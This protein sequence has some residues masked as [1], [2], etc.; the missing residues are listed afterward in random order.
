MLKGLHSPGGAA[1]TDSLVMLP[2]P[3]TIRCIPARHNLT[4]LQK[5]V[6]QRHF[7][8][9]EARRPVRPSRAVQHTPR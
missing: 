8:Y 4:Q 6:D 7:S 1:T 2:Y 3:G 5:F 9:E